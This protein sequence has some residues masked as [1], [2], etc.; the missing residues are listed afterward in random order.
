VKIEKVFY[1]K[2]E[3]EQEYWKHRVREYYLEKNG[4]ILSMNTALTEGTLWTFSSKKMGNAERSKLR[5]GRA[6]LFIT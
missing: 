4:L 6:M 1:K 3:R 5:Q 2:A